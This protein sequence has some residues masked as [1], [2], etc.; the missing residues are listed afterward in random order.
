[1]IISSS[2]NFK[3][4]EI[5]LI[6]IYSLISNILAISIENSYLKKKQIKNQELMD[7]LVAQRTIHLVENNKKLGD[8]IEK[9][10]ASL[11][12]SIPHEV[13]TPIN[14]I[15]GFSNFLMSYYGDKITEENK[16]MLDILTDIRNSANRLK[17]VFENFIYFTRL[18]L[19]STSIKEMEELQSKITYYCDSIIFDQAM[20]IAQRHN[21]VE[22][23]EINLISEHIN[24][25]EEYLAKLTAEVVDNSL[26]FSNAGTKVII[27]SNIQEKKYNIVFKD[28]GAGLDMDS[29]QFIDSYIQFERER[30]EQQGLGLGL[31]IV[32]KIVDLHNGDI[33]ISSKKEQFTEINISFR[34]A[35]N[36]SLE[37]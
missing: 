16:D 28:F 25:A 26:K 7:Q 10:K 1:M 8:K 24:I 11:S 21:R 4:V 35:E 3:E 9:L 27:N 32:H 13:R 29:I 18:S 6:D 15:L 5:S 30:K 34:I 22:D 37:L 17:D 36:A 23:M 31:S 33:S 19:I 20:I 12:M 14:Q 2:S